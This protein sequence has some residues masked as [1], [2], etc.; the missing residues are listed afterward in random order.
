VTLGND[1]NLY[2]ASDGGWLHALNPVSG[3]VYWSLDL[4]QTDRFA[5]PPSVTGAAIFLAGAGGAAHAVVPTTLELA[6]T[7]PLSG[8]PTTPVMAASE[9]LGLVFVGTSQGAVHALSVVL[10]RPIWR[11]Q[12]SAPVSG[13]AQDGTAVY[14]V[15]NDGTLSALWAWNGEARWTLKTSDGLPAAPLVDG[16]YVVAATNTSMVRYVDAQTGQEVK[17]WRLTVDGAILSSPAPAG[18][19]LFVRASRVVAFGP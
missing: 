3:E 7:S 11:A 1:G 13:L 5:Q 15:T 17:E 18:G 12:L 2:A 4:S 14:A 16:K 10:G 9:G 6:W 19:W 8:T